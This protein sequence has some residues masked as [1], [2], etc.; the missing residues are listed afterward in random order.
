MPRIL[1][2]GIPSLDQ[3]LGREETMTVRDL[4]I[5]DAN[6][7]A[8]AFVSDSDTRNKGRMWQRCFPSIVRGTPLPQIMEVL[9]EFLWPRDSASQ[10]REAAYHSESVSVFL[11]EAARAGALTITWVEPSGDRD[12]YQDPFTAQLTSSYIA[13]FGGGF[14][15]EDAPAREVLR[16]LRRLG[17]VLASRGVTRSADDTALQAVLDCLEPGDF[18]LV[19]R[20]ILD[21]ALAGALR[22]CRHEC[23]GFGILTQDEVTGPRARTTFCI[24]GAEG[25]GKSVLALHLAARYAADAYAESRRA[26]RQSSEVSFPPLPTIIYAST[27]LSFQK[28]SK[29]WKNFGLGRPNDRLIPL[30]TQE[31]RSWDSFREF[32]LRPCDC[33][34]EDPPPDDDPDF[35]CPVAPEALA[36]DQPPT[37]L[38]SHLLTGPEGANQ[39]F[40]FLDLEAHT[41]GDDWALLNRIVAALDP[42][43]GGQAPHVLVID[44]VEGLEALLGETDSFGMKRERRSRISQ[45]I[46]AARDKCHL[47]FIVE[48]AI[49]GESSDEDFVADVVIRLRRRMTRDYERRTVEV[50]KARAQSHSRGEHELVIRNG[51]GSKSGTQENSDD[52]RVPAEGP[53]Q[54]YVHVYQSLHNRSRRIMR[55][56]ARPRP[57]QTSAS[58]PR[59]G[60]CVPGFDQMLGPRARPTDSA[61]QRGLSLG[62][63]T[64]LM[65]DPGCHKSR[66]A[67]AFLAGAFAEA[68]P[69]VAVLFTADDLD[70]E[71]LARY[72]DQHLEGLPALGRHR[73][74]THTLCRRLEI[75]SVSSAVMIQIVEHTLKKAL[76]I[77][78]AS[79][80]GDADPGR[81]RVVIDTWSLLRAMYPEIGEDPLFLPFLSDVLQ[82]KGVTSLIIDEQPG[83]PKDTGLHESS[84]R[85]RSLARHH[86]YVWN[87]PFFGENRVALAAIPPVAD[88]M[89]TT[90]MELRP[91]QRHDRTFPGEQLE[92]DPHFQLYK[93]LESGNAERVPLEVRLFVETEASRQY[94]EELSALLNELFRPHRERGVITTD[95]PVSYENM[96][97]FK[98][99]LGDAALEHTLVR[100]VDEYWSPTREDHPVEIDYL[101]SRTG[102]QVTSQPQEQWEDW[103]ELFAPATEDPNL[104]GRRERGAARI[105]F[106]ELVDVSY[107]PKDPAQIRDPRK[108][109]RIPYTWEFGIL[110]CR[111]HAWL[112]ERSVVSKSQLRESDERVAMYMRWKNHS[113]MQ[114]TEWSQFLAICKDLADQQRALGEPDPIYPF[115]VYMV[116]PES[117]SCWILEM[118]AS[119]IVKGNRGPAPFRPTRDPILDPVSTNRVEG[120]T[121]SLTELLRHYRTELYKVMLLVEYATLPGQFTTR[122]FEFVP[123]PA[124]RSAI[125][126]RHW[127]STA[128]QASLEWDGKD[129]LVPI[130]LPGHFAVRGDWF[131]GI[132]NRSRSVMLGFQAADVLSSRRANVTRL[133]LGLGLPTR[134][135]IVSRDDTG[136][137]QLEDFRTALF[138][139]N[140]GRREYL[141]YQQL[142][143]LGAKQIGS[144]GLP[145]AA[146]ASSL[147]RDGFYWLWRSGIPYYHR[148]AR[149]FSKWLARI[150]QEWREV[151]RQ[152]GIQWADAL[153]LYKRIDRD[154]PDAS[155]PSR[156]EFQK[157]C[158]FAIRALHGA[159]PA[160]AAEA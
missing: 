14:P 160:I 54:A 98:R 62:S 113:E 157:R 21:I 155:P 64:G 72:L 68:E 116:T 34:P 9:N 109:D 137:S 114:P 154:E 6:L 148:H 80:F 97:N 20:L 71:R 2:F 136:V 58:A 122:N 50:V 10:S 151:R 57:D 101:Y 69:S 99:L 39:T 145:D 92:V 135:F 51:E 153:S 36:A 143:E 147:G 48:E 49:E 89:S 47:I 118:W 83:A 134:D 140:E 142:Q 87:V 52:P 12:L 59:A 141:S 67:R 149:V 28:A 46:R 107:P 53:F 106:F 94:I 100:Q 91:S 22:A 82:R 146:N 144:G 96:R 56:E 86:L 111:E 41:A 44:A 38:V 33:R 112:R 63:L 105:N 65:G 27:D 126:S 156:I 133:H 95:P 132:S 84:R 16:R 13:A 24:I 4:D 158:D 127:Y 18:A 85:L 115:D 119:E 35:P 131:L 88:N 15:I 110:L 29:V 124:H 102:T 77:L 76:R 123:R 104:D 139:T 11:R 93:G 19:K 37:Y 81:I 120:A 17:E 5:A 3:L 7:L 108:V 43:I 90:V 61:P 45:L 129:P 1:Q 23:E 75:H 73:L 31:Y 60:F 138:T 30:T 150:N 66:L 125:A 70:Q 152:D 79:S 32:R 128:A 25:T 130:G 26:D 40:A 8:E 159:T 74:Q 121:P 78:R 55:R 117:F 42:C 103:F